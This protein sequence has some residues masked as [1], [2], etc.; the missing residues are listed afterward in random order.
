MLLYIK[1]DNYWITFPH[2]LSMAVLPSSEDFI[3]DFTNKG[4]TF[5]ISGDIFP[6]WSCSIA[7]SKVI[8]FSE[9]GWT[10]GIGGA[11]IAG[12]ALALRKWLLWCS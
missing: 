2:V 9:G 7:S 11:T 1:T 6:C 3:F 12:A 8:W 10:A 4:S 5:S